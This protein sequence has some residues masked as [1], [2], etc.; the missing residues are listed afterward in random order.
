[1]LWEDSQ[2]SS[3]KGAS[4]DSDSLRVLGRRHP[5]GSGRARGRGR[6]VGSCAQH[7]FGEGPT[8]WTVRRPGWIPGE[9]AGQA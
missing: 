1:M 3:E 4:T 5:L 2:I 6:R 7:W 9:G 8:L